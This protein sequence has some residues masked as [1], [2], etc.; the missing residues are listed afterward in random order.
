M[1]LAMC[2]IIVLCISGSVAAQGIPSEYFPQ[3]PGEIT[4]T[5]VAPGAVDFTLRT[6]STERRRFCLIPP[7]F[8]RAYAQG[9]WAPINMEACELVE[10]GRAV[11]R[12]SVPSFRWSSSTVAAFGELHDLP[13]PTIIIRSFLLFFDKKGRARVKLATEEELRNFLLQ[14]PLAI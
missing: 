8:L 6:T 11:I 4:A 5:S 14:T 10:N 9:E 2:I 1:R 7:D 13:Y 12:F 3:A